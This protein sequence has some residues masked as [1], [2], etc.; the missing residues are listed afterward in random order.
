MGLVVPGKAKY[1]VCT[2]FL[3]VLRILICYAF[4]DG[5]VFP[6]I[7]AVLLMGLIGHDEAK[8]IVCV[9]FLLVS[10]DPAFS[11]FF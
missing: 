1:M 10:R 3:L 4:P 2:M 5:L 8:C 6:L 11:D 7:P 9:T